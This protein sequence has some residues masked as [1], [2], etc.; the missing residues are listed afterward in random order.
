MGCEMSR[1]SHNLDN[2]LTDGGEVT[3]LAATLTLPPAHLC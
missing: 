3:L 1:I 2:L